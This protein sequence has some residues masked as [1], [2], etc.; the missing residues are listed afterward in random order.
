MPPGQVGNGPTASVSARYFDSFKVWSDVKF[1]VGINLGFYNKAGIANLEKLVKYSCQ[2]LGDR[3]VMWE[4]GNEPDLLPNWGQRKKSSWNIPTYVAQWKDYASRVVDQAKASCGDSYDKPFYGPSIA[5]SNT[6]A[7]GFNDVAAFAA[8]INS[9]PKTPIA[10]LSGHSY[11]GGG[12]SDADLSII[13]S[14]IKVKNAVGKFMT[15]Q[16]ALSKYNLPFTIGEGN[17]LTG[18]G[19]A[20]VSNVFG[21]ALWAADFSL[22][23]AANSDKITRSHFHQTFSTTKPSNY[24]AWKPISNALGG[25]STNPPYYGHLLAAKTIG[26]EELAKIYEVPLPGTDGLDSMYVAYDSTGP[27]RITVIN[28]KQWTGSGTR[29]TRTYTVKLPTGGN[30][31]ASVERLQASTATSQTGVT[32]G[33]KSYDFETR[34]ME[35]AASDEVRRLSAS[36]VK[37]DDNTLTIDVPD[38]EA[39]LVTLSEDANSSAPPSQTTTLP[40]KT[41]AP[42]TET[43]AAAPKTT[44]SLPETYGPPSQTYAPE[45]A[46]AEESGTWTYGWDKYKCLPVHA[47]RQDD[48]PFGW[49]DCSK[50]Q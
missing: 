50:P 20:G 24:N 21:A 25:P 37:V 47:P 9:D 27:K 12:R 7:K 40:P 41:S 28:M 16:K 29:S 26:S 1:T 33:G 14:H 4:V 22:Y 42:P 39:V 31:A 17:S 35:K 34:G 18:G 23:I 44:P 48:L 49:I 13:M 46:S 2:A 15:L 8:G 11:M 32:F 5:S 43:S 10:Q 3:L 38:S 6:G 36:G 45:P 19:K 30:W